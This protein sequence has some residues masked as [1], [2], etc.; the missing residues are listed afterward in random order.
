LVP[1]CRAIVC[2]FWRFVCY[3]CWSVGYK[4]AFRFA[5]SFFFTLTMSSSS[6]DVATILDFLDAEA[7]ESSGEG[8]PAPSATSKES[9]PFSRIVLTPSEALRDAQ[10]IFAKALGAFEFACRAFILCA[11]EDRSQRWLEIGPSMVSL[12]WPSSFVTFALTMSAP[13]FL[14]TS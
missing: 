5:T 1:K 6:L 4:G 2:V 9:L 13:F 10:N 12:L 8:S 14:G 11:P 7:V 3:G